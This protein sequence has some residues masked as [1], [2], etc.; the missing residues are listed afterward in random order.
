MSSIAALLAE[1]PCKARQAKRIP[2]S[3]TAFGRARLGGADGGQK[4]S[5][6]VVALGAKAA[7][8]FGAVYEQCWSGMLFA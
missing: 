1:L 8:S 7:D 2:Y 3:G 6:F 5:C 4:G